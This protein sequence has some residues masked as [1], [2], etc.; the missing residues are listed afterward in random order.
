V[1]FADFWE[2]HSPLLYYL[3][4]PLTAASPT[5][6]RVYFVGRGL[7]ALAAAGALLLVYRLAVRLSPGAALG[8]DAARLPP[9][10]VSTRP[11]CG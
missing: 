7:M 2:H 3:L 4:A 1:P 5:A 9:R 8:R 11:R 6:R 10:F